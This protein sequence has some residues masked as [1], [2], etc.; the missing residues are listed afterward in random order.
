[1]LEVEDNGIGMDSKQVSSIFAPFNQ[2]EPESPRTAGGLGLGLTICKAIADLH[3]AKLVA[4]SRGRGRGSRF[5]LQMEAA[6]D[7][8]AR[9]PSRAR[10]PSVVRPS[11]VALPRTGCRVLLVEDHA[12]TAELVSDLLVAEGFKVDWARSISDALSIDLAKV[13]V[14]VS[15]LGLPDGNGLDLIRTLQETRHHPAIALSGFG[16]GSD[17]EASLQAG[18]DAH[19][20]K[21]VD[22][23]ELL[24]T[25]R[26]VTARARST[27]ADRPHHRVKGAALL[28]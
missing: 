15:D 28:R 6:R 26:T 19:L 3:G 2:L 4:V 16:M 20:T 21:P 23:G 24:Y 22:I 18:F 10:A 17:V 11:A 9:L 5:V 7:Q 8:S 25:I 27:T 12:D 13:D 14:I 1:M